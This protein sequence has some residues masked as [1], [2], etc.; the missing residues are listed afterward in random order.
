MNLEFGVENFQSIKLGIH[1]VQS[2]LI[3]FSWILEI[4]VFRKADIIN[5]KTGWYFGVC[6]LTLPAIIYLTMTRRYQQT[7][8][9]ANPYALAV[10]DAVYCLL[11]LTAFAAQASYNGA[12]TGTGKDEKHKCSGACGASKV[13]VGLGVIVW[14][15]WIV[16]FIMSCAGVFL[17]KR[18]GRLPGASRVPLNAQQIDPHKDA[19]STDPND[20]EYA[21]LHLNERE[22]ELPDTTG[23]Y[24]G[25]AGSYS[26]RHEQDLHTP[27]ISFSG[28]Y[29]PPRVEDEETHYGGAYGDADG[30]K[31]HFPDGDYR[32]V[33]VL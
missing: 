17:Y 10:V 8:K 2:A 30:G 12:V 32:H 4:V 11:W 1:C 28:G 26:S 33:R 29:V 15:L 24:G 13:I 6:L 21:R 19:F 14:L 22:H 9:F 3:L 18:D 20:E 7:E 23:G 16:T 27:G 31:A 25:G 5:G